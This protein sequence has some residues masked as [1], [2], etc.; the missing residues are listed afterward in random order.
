MY[1]I[2]SKDKND[3]YFFDGFVEDWQTG[4]LYL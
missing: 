1:F 3:A 2:A 4:D